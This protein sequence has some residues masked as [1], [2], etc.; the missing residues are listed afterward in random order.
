MSNI[1]K[2]FSTSKYLNIWEDS[3]LLGIRHIYLQKCS[4]GQALG[5]RERHMRAEAQILESHW[6]LLCLD[7]APE[8]RFQGLFPLAS[9]VYFLKRCWMKANSVTAVSNCTATLLSKWRRVSHHNVWVC[10]LIFLQNCHF[11]SGFCKAA[12]K[13]VVTYSEPAGVINGGRRWAQEQCHMLLCV[14]NVLL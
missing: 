12:S 6:C 5:R 3:W 10:S 1:Y 7:S 13:K 14:K 8:H 4:P 11:V 9:G 2:C